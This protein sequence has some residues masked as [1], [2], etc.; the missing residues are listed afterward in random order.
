MDERAAVNAELDRSLWNTVKKGAE[1]S[2]LTIDNYL[3][4]VLFNLHKDEGV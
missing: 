2:N 1:F 3:E 4:K